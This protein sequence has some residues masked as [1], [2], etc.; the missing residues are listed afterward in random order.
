MAHFNAATLEVKD[1]NEYIT[2]LTLKWE[3]WNGQLS[4]FLNKNFLRNYANLLVHAEKYAQAEK[5]PF[6]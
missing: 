2:I 5:K 1:F 4:F 3:L 6:P